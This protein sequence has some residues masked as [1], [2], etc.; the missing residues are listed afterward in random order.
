MFQT[1]NQLRII[2]IDYLV[3]VTMGSLFPDLSADD[4]NPVFAM[5][6][7]VCQLQ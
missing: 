5:G 1:T 4:Q 3:L 7:L 2:V 6:V